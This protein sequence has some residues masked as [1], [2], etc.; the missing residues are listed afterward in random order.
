MKPYNLVVLLLTLVFQINSIKSQ[1]TKDSLVSVE[2]FADLT[3]VSP[4]EELLIA[5]RYILE[6]G[7]HIYWRNPGDSGIPTK[8]DLNLPEGFEII[9]Y[10]WPMP[11]R[12][13]EGGLTSFGYKDEAM[14][15]VKVKVKKNVK[16]GEYEITG[17][18]NWLV[19]K[20]KCLPGSAATKFKFKVDSISSINPEWDKT[21]DF[22]DDMPETD[23]DLEVNT[24]YNEKHF[25]I[26]VFLDEPTEDISIFP[27]NEGVFAISKEPII[28]RTSWGVKIKIE[29]SELMFEVP[30]KIQGIIYLEEEGSAIEF[31]SVV[32]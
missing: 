6:E 13:V 25:T 27:Y 1:D 24:S 10:L 3:V 18:T 4:E 7:W 11:T 17:K 31:E 12:F 2:Q 22:R 23:W 15:F 26:S 28:E 8:I 5:T 14:I 32:N 19:C 9:D 20:E 16:Y 21:E 29:P 30:K